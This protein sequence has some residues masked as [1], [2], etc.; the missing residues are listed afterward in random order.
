MRLDAIY[1][2]GI[3]SW[4]TTVNGETNER[5]V[6]PIQNVARFSLL[7]RALSA[8]LPHNKAENGAPDGDDAKDKNPTGDL[9]TDKGK[10]S[11]SLLHMDH[12]WKN[13]TSLHTKHK[14]ST[15]L[16]NT[17][18]GNN[19]TS[20]MNTGNGKNSTSLSSLLGN[21]NITMSTITAVQKSATTQL[22]V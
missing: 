22:Q 17:G 8:L 10:N 14:N 13:S 11:T 15:S 5:A 4:V 21:N 19:S 16:H 9:D 18:T 20:L 7:D 6:E 1:V 3:L 2:L 12:G